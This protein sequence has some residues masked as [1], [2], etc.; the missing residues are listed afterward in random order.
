MHRQENLPKNIQHS[1]HHIIVTMEVAKGKHTVPEGVAVE[2]LNGGT[3]KLSAQCPPEVKSVL[4][5]HGLVVVYDKMV[6]A[7]CKQGDTRSAFGRWKDAE[8]NNII[9]LFR[10]EFS[11]KGVKI[12]L[13]KR[14][15][16]G[17]THRWIE[18]IDMNKV[19]DYVPQYD[20][21]N[22]S[23]QVIKT[24]FTT[25]EF[26][27]GVA[28][29]ELKAWKNRQALR[30]TIPIFVEKMLTAKDLMT[31]YEMLVE[32]CIESGVGPNTK[33]W[34]IGNLK[35]IMAKYQPIF[36]KKGVAVFISHKQEF[37]S[38]GQYGGH[39]EYFRWIEFVNREE[40][41]NYQPQRDANAKDEQ[42]CAVM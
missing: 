36:E 7:I 41:P 30:D 2:E 28:V 16:G 26:P 1:F 3:K 4:E 10:D 34:N 38:H 5:S 8:F 21:N 31:E 35:E 37:I 23:G 27:Y 24:C 17:G 14:Q 6:D 25:L 40:Q 9:D 39:Y 20:T 18:F 19:G 11:E 15:S 42:G 22:Y 12:A 13:C 32:E 29:E 33:M